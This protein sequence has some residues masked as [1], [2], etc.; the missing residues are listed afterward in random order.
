MFIHKTS[1]FTIYFGDAVESVLLEEIGKQKNTQ[2][3][4][5]IAQRI[6]AEHI[7]LLRQEHRVQGRIIELSDDQSYFF[8]STG[9]YLITQKKDYGI[10]VVTGD[11][12][13][14]VI[15]DRVTHTAGIVHAG[16]KGLLAGVFQIAIDD[17]IEKKGVYVAHLE[18]YLGPAARSCC[19]EVQQD[20]VDQFKKYENDPFI[21]IKK[22]GKTYFDSQSFIIVIAR[23]LGI[24]QEKLY[25]RYNVCTICN[26]SFC[27]YRREQEK[28]RRQVTMICLH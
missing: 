27:S 19:Y 4:Q 2:N 14:I 6:Q 3:L 17:M 26:L 8:Q 7:A 13:S 25:T 15:Y 10:G 12:L 16:W 11:C 5:K 18:I 1:E 28:A 24:E 20:F 21:F 22:D 9:D 23:S